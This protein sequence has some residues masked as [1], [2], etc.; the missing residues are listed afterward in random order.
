MR[1]RNSS[2]CKHYDN[3]SL[4]V[5]LFNGLVLTQEMMYWKQQEIMVLANVFLPTSIKRQCYHN[6]FTC[7][8]S[9]VKNPLLD[10]NCR[11]NQISN[12]TLAI[13]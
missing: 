1:L 4:L 10:L 7:D 3:K 2:C 13:A 9:V 6:Y 11:D 12:R 5:S 8:T